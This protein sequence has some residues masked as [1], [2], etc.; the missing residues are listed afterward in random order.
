M[1]K[2]YQRWRAN[3]IKNPVEKEK[4]LA[5]I[6]NEPWV[7][8]LTVDFENPADPKT[9]SMELDWNDAFIQNLVD[10]G[11]SGRTQEEIVDMW[12]RDLCRGVINNEL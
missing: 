8:V 1:I 11:Y 12:F 7:K 5:T 10:A 6:D 2:W 3:K 9:G 4:T